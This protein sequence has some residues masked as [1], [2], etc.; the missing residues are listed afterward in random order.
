MLAEEEGFGPALKFTTF[1][2]VHVKVLG[3][4]PRISDCMGN[5]FPSHPNLPFTFPMA[6]FAISSF[7]IKK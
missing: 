7:F 2:Y 5:S 4:C 6:V 1:L 3:N